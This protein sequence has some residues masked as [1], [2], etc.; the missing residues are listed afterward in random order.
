M[1]LSTGERSVFAELTGAPSTTLAKLDR[2]A[3]LLVEWDRKFN[4]VASSTL[5]HIWSR[6]FLDSAQLIKLMPQSP[7]APHD[8]GKNPI[9]VD[10]GA[11][12]GFPGL[13]LDIMG[14]PNIHLVESIGKKADFLRAAIDDLSL[15]ATVHHCRIE[16]VRGLKADIITARALAPLEKLLA[17]AAPLRKSNAVCLFLKG[18]NIDAELTEAQKY[19]MFD[20]VKVQSLSGPDGSVLV[21]RNLKKH[22]NRRLK[23]SRKP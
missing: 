13:V 1:K 4:L 15:S 19:W 8:T 6:H 18:Q 3:E 10:L 11:G 21:I 12:A 5:P 17:L 16:S 9:L 22:A 14:I 23:F 2:Y 7:H 20:H